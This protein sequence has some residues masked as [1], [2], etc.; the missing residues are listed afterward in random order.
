MT[1]GTTRP[2]PVVAL[3]A[4]IALLGTITAAVWLLGRP[5]RVDLSAE[6][7]GPRRLLTNELAYWAPGRPGTRQSAS[8]QVTSGSLF[9]DHGSGWTGVPDDRRADP[10]SSRG[11]HSAVFRATSRRADFGAVSVQFELAD[12]GVGSTG[13]TP[14]RGWD[15][16]HVFLRFRGE[17]LLYVASID[18]RD[19]TV[20]VKK[21][22]AGGDANGG[23]YFTLGRAEHQVHHGVWRRI[24]ATIVDDADGHV[25]IR[26]YED[27]R[28]LL[29]VVDDG[30]HGAPIERGRIGLRGDNC[31]FRF[32]DFIV[33]KLTGRAARREA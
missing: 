28:L 13:T 2:R 3:S 22:T 20:V 23:T 32:R 30:R 9:A 29:R 12:Q 19:D 31:N 15:G 21:K 24:R 10:S 25:V 5:D 8:W 14:P 27:G 11:T 17:S 4:L 6:F 7:G 33:T 1:I 18:R 26:L 16:V